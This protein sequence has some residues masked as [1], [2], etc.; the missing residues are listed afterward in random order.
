[1]PELPDLTVYVEHLRRRVVGARLTAIRLAS[2][3]LLRTVRPAVAD[4]TG[5][6][7]VGVRRLA[8]QI[9]LAFEADY[10]AVIHLMIA[11]RLRWREGVAA[12]PK[13]VGLAAF[14]FDITCG[15]GRQR[16]TLLFTEAS[17]KRRAALRLAQGEAA[18]AALHP[19]GLEVETAPLGAFASRLRATPHT[20]K[21]A[22]TDQRVIAGIGNAYS[23][24]ILFRARL[25]PFKLGRHL[26]DAEAHRLFDACRSV[27]ADWTLRLRANAAHA[28]PGDGRGNKVTAFHPQMAVHGRYKQPCPRCGAPVQRI[29][30]PENESN[31]CAMCQTG[32][33]L[34]ADRALSRLLKDTYPK[35]LE[36]LEGGPGPVE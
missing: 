32:G 27:L 10:F 22:L 15:D 5:R 8:K 34:L 2:P 17:K 16:A 7:V 13:R 6:Q 33:R 3:F 20:I 12:V 25:S 36:D 26:S 23:D 24:E 28:F 18:L 35:R 4:V 1:M 31:Y 9:V 21:R 29:V 30:R 14:D 19:G 11:G